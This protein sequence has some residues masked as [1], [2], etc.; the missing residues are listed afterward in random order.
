MRD[1]ADIRIRRLKQQRERYW[2]VISRAMTAARR[3]E[4][5]LESKRAPAR[6]A[7]ERASLER[8][9]LMEHYRER[10]A[11]GLA[12]EVIAKT[13]ASCLNREIARLRVQ[14][15]WLNRAA[16]PEDV[17][18]RLACDA[19]TCPCA[20]CAETMPVLIVRAA[21]GL[22][23]S[24]SVAKRLRGP[25]RSVSVYTGE[26]MYRRR[27]AAVVGLRGLQPSCEFDTCA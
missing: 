4:S 19:P 3:C 2:S 7:I 23:L 27:G 26:N 17:R 14:A 18:R 22:C 11:Q 21:H 24:Q 1:G 10:M 8:Y 15:W 9:D 16:L 5:Y 6:S 13:K 12:A 25:Q 20:T